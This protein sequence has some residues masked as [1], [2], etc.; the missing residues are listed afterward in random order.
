MVGGYLRWY[1]ADF[2]SISNPPIT[3]NKFQFE[4]LNPLV[5]YKISHSRQV[6]RLVGN[7]VS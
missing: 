7:F 1:P 3:R 6:C 4:M 2:F 5:T